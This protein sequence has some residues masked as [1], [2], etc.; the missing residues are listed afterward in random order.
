MTARVRQ[1][2]AGPADLERAWAELGRVPL[3]YEELVP[4][5]LEVSV[6]GVRSRTGE[7]R[8]YPLNHN[9]H[10][11]GILR[12]TRAPYDNARLNRMAR[13][14]V[15]AVMQKLRYV[16]VLTIEF[17]VRSGRLLANEMAP[18]VHNSGHWTI[19]GAVTS[20]F[21]EPPACHSRATPGGNPRRG[22][23]RH[24][25]SDK[26]DAEEGPAARS[27]WGA[28]ARLCQSTTTRSQTGASDCGRR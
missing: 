21:R 3:L 28:P 16:G 11:D 9:L 2:C 10:S 1:C 19:E 20:Q 6:I 7:C 27:P 5:D 17:F 8:V 26:Y 18:R 23:Q 24:D 25:Q 14:H 12:L 13:Q 4:F 22:V 15:L